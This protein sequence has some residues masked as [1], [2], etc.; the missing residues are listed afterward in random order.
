MVPCP[1]FVAS[2]RRLHSEHRGA[3]VK[4]ARFALTHEEQARGKKWCLREVATEARWFAGRASPSRENGSPTAHWHYAAS[5][6]L[7]VERRYVEQ[8][9]G[10]D[11]GYHGWGEEDMDF[12]YRCTGRGWVSFFRNP[13][14]FMP[15]ISTTTRQITGPSLWSAM[16]GDSWANS[17]EVYESACRR[18]RPAVSHSA[19]NRRTGAARST[20][21]RAAYTRRAPWS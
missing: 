21:S 11:E 6:A 18:T 3:V 7:S 9:G 1:N 15:S 2:L 5:N 17:L 4:P 16:R 13:S 8:I 14:G 20:N 19:G 12:A 10:W